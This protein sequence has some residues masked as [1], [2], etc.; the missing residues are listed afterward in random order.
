MLV[1]AGELSPSS[2]QVRRSQFDL[3]LV[4]LRDFTTERETAGE[5]LDDLTSVLYRRL[6][7]AD[8]DDIATILAHVAWAQT[9]RARLDVP[10]FVD[11]DGLFTRA[12]AASPRNV[13]ANAFHG[14]WLLIRRG[15]DPDDVRLAQERFR[16]AL[17][18][19]GDRDL[20]RRRQLRALAGLN[21]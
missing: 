3:A 20:V 13:H 11:I 7:H 21:V 14:E 9:L 18:G 4:W 6:A 10:V 17:D 12:L 16:V 2:A 1:Q 19:G 8:D 5:T 15:T